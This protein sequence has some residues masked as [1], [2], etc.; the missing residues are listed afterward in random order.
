V[1]EKRVKCSA[2]DEEVETEVPKRVRQQ[3]K[4]FSAA[5]F[6]T[7]VNDGTSVYKFWWRIFRETNVFPSF[8]YHMFYVLYPFV[9]HVLIFTHTIGQLVTDVPSGLNFYPTSRNNKK[10]IVG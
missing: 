10:E 4:Y 3:S 7:L 1:V 5:G 6:D 2:D 9:T 8:Q